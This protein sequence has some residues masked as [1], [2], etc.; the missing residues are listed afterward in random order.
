MILLWKLIMNDKIYS[1]KKCTDSYILYY[2]KI[3]F[4]LLISLGIIIITIISFIV[5]SVFVIK[6]YIVEISGIGVVD[7]SS[8]LVISNSSYVE[9]IFVKEG[10]EVEVGDIILIQN[11][12]IIDSK[13][14]Q[15]IYLY[16]FYSNRVSLYDRLIN[17]IE[18]DY[19]L[20]E[21]G[22]SFDRNDLIELEFYNYMSQYID[23]ISLCDDASA[24]IYKN[25]I[26]ND[27]LKSR[28]DTIIQFEQYKAQLES[29]EKEKNMYIIRAKTRG[30]V[31]FDTRIDNGIYLSAGTYIGSISAKEGVKILA[32]IN[33]SD[34]NKIEL[35]MDAKIVVKGVS[36]NDFGTVNGKIISID[37]NSIASENG[38]YYKTYIEL[39][40]QFVEFNDK[41]IEFHTGT[42]FIVRISYEEMT[43]F[44]FFMEKLG[45]SK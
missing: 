16:D 1:F 36:Q 32:Y 44:S 42:E 17:Y 35:G 8:S 14:N 19:K 30:I 40:Q 25:K 5:W 3:P 43:F 20:E 24:K 27:Y 22:K 37:S 41:K 45:F 34:R 7:N 21:E 9:E 31:H 38:N 39:E 18:N 2:K 28:A 4:F 26:E 23:Q 29:Y 6:P 33:D 13:I 12:S 15:T 11:A 10:D